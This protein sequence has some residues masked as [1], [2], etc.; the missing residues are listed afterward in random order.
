[1]KTQEF[2]LFV[3]DLVAAFLM[4][5][6]DEANNETS[7]EVAMMSDDEFIQAVE[8][9][10]LPD[11][12]SSPDLVHESYDGIVDFHRCS[13]FNGIVQSLHKNQADCVDVSLKDE[14]IVFFPVKSEADID[15]LKLILG[16]FLPND[17]NWCKYLCRIDGTFAN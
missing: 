16:G 12:Y 2:G 6:L 8:A 4:R 11:D 7:Y 15:D 14:A 10:A 13:S 5:G 9:E 17:F 1:M 3:D